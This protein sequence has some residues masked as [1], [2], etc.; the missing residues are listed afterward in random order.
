MIWRNRAKNPG[1]A[2]VSHFLIPVMR[3]LPSFAAVAVSSITLLSPVF[4]ADE[5]AAVARIDQLVLEGLKKEGLEPNADASD[6]VFVRR[7][8]LDL[9]GRI[10]TKAETLAFLESADP[11]K[12]A[13][14]V[15]SL[16]GS[17]GY[18]SHFYNWYADLL[19]MRTSISG[20]T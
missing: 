10:P 14:L 19:R 5:T 8:H 6:E 3:I 20:K 12:R 18:V 7:V 15:D 13:E 17:D 4:G 9:I 16:I 1:V 2:P 11:D